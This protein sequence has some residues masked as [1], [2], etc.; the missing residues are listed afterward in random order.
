VC[1]TKKKENPEMVNNDELHADLNRCRDEVN[2]ISHC[3]GNV[4]KG[5][6]ELGEAQK[7]LRDK[8][9]KLIE[10]EDKIDRLIEESEKRWH[11]QLKIRND[12][13]DETTRMLNNQNGRIDQLTERVDTLFA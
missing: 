4:E 8:I 3:L 10:K 6:K 7:E 9:I 5:H 13:K 11:A 1:S 2:S 12:N